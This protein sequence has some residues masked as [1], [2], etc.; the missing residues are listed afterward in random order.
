MNIE[1]LFQEINLE[2]REVEFK[3]TLEEG[4]NSKSDRLLDRL[5]YGWLKT[6]NAFA[7]TLGGTLFVGV[8]NKTHRILSL[9]ANEVDVITL[10]FHR[11]VK[12]HIH[13]EIDYDIEAIPVNEGK[14]PRFLLKI[15]IKR[16]ETLPVTMNVNGFNFIFIRYYGKNAPATPEQIRSLS[17]EGKNAVFDTRMTK[18]LFSPERF[19][20]LFTAYEEKMGKTLNEKQLIDA[21]FMDK[22]HHL[23]MGA[24]F[25]ADD[26][27]ED[28]TLLVATKIQGVNKGSD[29]FY[30]SKEI[31]GN[32]IDVLKESVSFVNA[33]AA[34]GFRKTAS[35]SFPYVAYPAQSLNEGIA[36]AIAHRNYFLDGT[37]IELNLYDDRLEIISPGSYPLGEN[38]TPST[39]IATIAPGRRNEVICAVLSLLG[40]IDKKGSGFDKIA[41]DY[42]GKGEAFRP[43]VTSSA[44]YFSLTLPDLTHVGGLV[45]RNEF[46]EIHVPPLIT[47]EKEIAILRYCYAKKRSAM[48]IASYIGVTPSSYFRKDVLDKLVQRGYLVVDESQRPAKFLANRNNVIAR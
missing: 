20:K 36:N 32:L 43:F 12:E 9:S 38:I 30:Q 6:V 24:E 1:D 11:L 29:Y 13:P 14:A 27:Y 44:T 45:E 37:Q 2:T 41:E 19:H 16:S 25:F 17:L 8:E 7:N 39:D 3:G 40:Y 35:G 22:D 33:H 18:A 34:N 42:R 4:D 28:K 31:R 46:P 21:R 10:R 5:E 48:E 15:L 23:S 47:S 26:Y